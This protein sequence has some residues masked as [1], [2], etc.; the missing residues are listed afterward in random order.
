MC[1]CAPC[2]LS[3][4]RVCARRTWLQKD[5]CLW[6]WTSQRILA[7]S[8]RTSAQTKMLT[9]STICLV[10]QRVQSAQHDFRQLPRS[11][12]RGQRHVHVPSVRAP[13]CE[14]ASAPPTSVSQTCMQTQ[15]NV[16][17][18]KTRRMMPKQRAVIGVWRTKKNAGCTTRHS[19]K[20]SNSK[21]MRRS[22][23]HPAWPTAATTCWDFSNGMI[24]H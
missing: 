11:T 5:F 17:G 19:A 8:T 12:Q 15:L 4:R 18:Q 7:A 24:G 16:Q 20:S 9:C 14:C 10:L 1:T 6:T 2:A 21:K 23:C 13:C 3:Q 22:K